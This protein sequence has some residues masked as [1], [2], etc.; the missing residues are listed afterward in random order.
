MFTSFRKHRWLWFI[1]FAFVIVSFVFFFSPQQPSLEGLRGEG[2]VVGSVN[3]KPLTLAQY[4]DAYRE[5]YLRYWFTYG[6]EPRNDEIM[7][8]LGIM[9]RETR[10]RL[11]LKELIRDLDIKVPDSAVA[12]WIVENFRD[13]ETGVFQREFYDRF[14]QQ[15]LPRG[16]TREDFRRF[17]RHEVG[18][19][20]LIAV[21]GV[22]GQLVTPQEAEMLYKRENEKVDAQAILLTGNDFL[23]QVVVE[24]EEV[25]R[26]YTN[27]LANYRLPEKIQIQHVRFEAGDYMGEAAERLKKQKDLEEII[28]RIYLQQGPEAFTGEDGEPLPEDEAKEQIEEELRKDFALQEAH[29]RAIEF[30]NQLFELPAGQETFSQLA[31]AEGHLVQVTAPFTRFDPPAELKLPPQIAQAVFDLT[32]DQ[33][34]L[35]QPVVSEDGVYVAA[36]HRRIP[37][38]IQ[39]LEQVEDRVV[40]DYRRQRAM[41]LARSAG[42]ELQTLISEQLSE[43]KSFE[44]AAA[45]AEIE[46]LDLTPFSQNTPAIP[47][48]GPRTADFSAI[49]NIA[50]MLAPGEISEFTPTREGGFILHLRERLMVD[51][52]T[53]EEELP[54]YLRSLRQRR[55]LE[56]FSNWFRREMELARIVLPEDRDQAN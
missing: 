14:L 53:L 25:A 39:P 48:L 7:R 32:P 29:R 33:P 31:D 47:E 46:I 19:Q 2:Q 36:L 49:K 6:R 54:E 17:A 41:E 24:S 5:A 1:I 28:D 30:V 42:E 51:D 34:F 50:F 3:G 15:G 12:Q 27:N 16:F 56:A 22:S 11:L 40:E 8:Q 18:L 44:E 55:Q 23:E 10:Q 13:P 21:G 38:E 26:F 20:H 37:S 45:E 4:H 43:G 35:E 9:E 52:L